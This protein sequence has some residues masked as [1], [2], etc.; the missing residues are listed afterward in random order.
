MQTKPMN[1]EAIFGEDVAQSENTTSE[2]DD[3]SM[4]K[5]DRLKADMT[6]ELFGLYA[7]YEQ[8]VDMGRLTAAT[9]AAGSEAGEPD[10]KI[11]ALENVSKDLLKYKKSL[12]DEVADE[13]GN[14]PMFRSAFPV[15]DRDGF[16]EEFY[17]LDEEREEV[18]GIGTVEDED[19]LV[20]PIVNG[21]H[22]NPLISAGIDDSEADEEDA[23][24]PVEDENV[25][26]NVEDVDDDRDLTELPGVGSAGSKQLF[27]AGFTTVGQ[28]KEATPSELEAVEGVGPKTA[29][30]LSEAEPEIEAE[31]EPENV[32]DEIEA[33]EKAGDD[34]DSAKA[35]LLKAIT[36]K[37]QNGGEISEAEAQIVSSL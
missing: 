3:D 7:D 30:K 8:A 15:E 12:A 6:D 31:P 10:E 32:E 27:R 20:L 24:L 23:E 13:A 25:E 37:I 1:V 14:L 26:E 9:I 4:T 36:E 5:I 19:E 29:A 2:A 11:A 18:L 22:W 35:D 21:E 34:V 33:D 28:V 16:G 17:V